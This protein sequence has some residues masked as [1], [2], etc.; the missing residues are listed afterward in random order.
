LEDKVV[1]IEQIKVGS[2]QNFSYII[3]D[4]ESRESAVVDPAW[5][6]PLIIKTL[7][8]GKWNAKYII[9]THSH[10]DHIHGN[11]LLSK[12]TG[13]KIVMNENSLAKKDIAASDGLEIRLGSRTSVRLI[14]TPGHSPESMCIL[15]NDVALLTGD[16]L[17]IGKCG[18]VD[19]PGGDASDLYDSFEKIR[20]LSPE[21]IVFPGH[22]Y[23]STASSTLGEQLRTNYTLAKR[24]RDEFVK[25]MNE[26]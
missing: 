10:S 17:F 24:S 16:T 8:S 13:A 25:F 7:A 1:A 22:D 23:G 20:A 11:P 14:H 19:L 9:N 6:V 18:R 2:Y 3:G 5:D 12:E 26:P 15:V 4:K 21:L